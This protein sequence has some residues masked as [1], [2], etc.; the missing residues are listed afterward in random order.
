[1][2]RPFGL[3]VLS[4]ALFAAAFARADD[5]PS[6]EIKAILSKLHTELKS[7]TP[8]VRAAAYTAIGE[9]G[10]KAHGERR[11]LCQGLLDA[12]PMVQTAA[13]DA[14]KKV[15]EPLSKTALALVI[16]KD[17]KQVQWAHDNPKKAG[18]LVPLLFSLTA[19]LSPM[20][21]REP[22]VDGAGAAKHGEARRDF[23]ACV[24]ALVAVEPD[25]P[26][27]NKAVISMLG[28]P[29]ADNREAALGHVLALKNKKLALSPVLTLAGNAKETPK[30]RVLAI[31]LVPDL[32]DE[33]TTPN[34]VKSLEALRFEQNAEIREAIAD[35][36][37][38]LK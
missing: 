2:R 36:V 28:N 20:A 7:K 18:P 11:T 1:M 16:D 6:P 24:A 38:K 14:L 17:M 26:E 34:A 12:N 27:V 37:K 10:D 30:N 8:K 21:S 31:K 3:L 15:D 5:E 13:A 25:G 22:P 32:V 33:N 23:R 19:S 29:R 9:L 35:S 4:S